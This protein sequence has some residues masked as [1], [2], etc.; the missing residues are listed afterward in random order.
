MEKIKSDITS[1]MTNFSCAQ[2]VFGVNVTF[3][4]NKLKTEDFD[5]NF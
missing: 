4:Q 5:S 1:G 2:D 3:F